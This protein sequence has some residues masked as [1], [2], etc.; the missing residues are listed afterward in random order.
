MS[1]QRPSDRNP[2]GSRGAAKGLTDTDAGKRLEFV[3]PYRDTGPNVQSD[4]ADSSLSNSLG[5]IYDRGACMANLVC[6]QNHSQFSDIADSLSRMKINA[7]NKPECHS[8]MSE[9]STTRDKFHSNSI[10][11]RNT[12]EDSIY[13]R[14]VNSLADTRFSEILAGRLNDR[15]H[16]EASG[17]DQ[18]LLN[19][20]IHEFTENNVTVIQPT[21]DGEFG[22]K[23]SYLSASSSHMD[24]EYERDALESE[25]YRIRNRSKYHVN[26]TNAE[27]QGLYTSDKIGKHKNRQ[28]PR[29]ISD[30]TVN[31]HVNLV[32]PLLNRHEESM[33]KDK[34]DNIE[35]NTTVDNSVKEHMFISTIS[36]SEQLITA[37]IRTP[38][39]RALQSVEGCHKS[40][41]KVGVNADTYGSELITDISNLSAI[42]NSKVNSTG[43]HEV[44]TSK[45][46]IFRRLSQQFYQSPTKF[47]EDLITLIEESVLHSKLEDVHASD[48]S[49]SRLTE[50]FRKICQYKRIED[51]SVPESAFGTS[52]QILSSQSGLKNQTVGN[53]SST[54]AVAA[55]SPK[56]NFTK[57]GG[58]K[59]VYRKTPRRVIKPCSMPN[60]ANVSPGTPKTTSDTNYIPDVNNSTATFELFENLCCANSPTKQEQRVQMADLDVTEILNMEDY[61]RKSDRQM[62]ALEESIQFLEEIENGVK[63]FSHNENVQPT[64]KESEAQSGTTVVE[65][66]GPNENNMEVNGKGNCQKIDKNCE[67]R[68]IEKRSKCFEEARKVFEQQQSSVNVKCTSK[69]SASHE[70]QS[71]LESVSNAGFVSTL[72]ACVDYFD[73]IRAI[74]NFQKSLQCILECSEETESVKE[75]TEDSRQLEYV[76]AIILPIRNRDNIPGPKSSATSKPDPDLGKSNLITQTHLY[77]SGS[78]RSPNPGDR[79]KSPMK[80]RRLSPG[81]RRSPGTQASSVLAKKI[82]SPVS[83]SRRQNSHRVKTNG[84]TPQ[85]EITT[86]ENRRINCENK[87]RALSGRS[88]NKSTAHLSLKLKPA[89]SSPGLTDVT[90]INKPQIIPKIVITNSTPCDFEKKSVCSRNTYENVEIDCRKELGFSES[91]TPKVRKTRY[92]VTPT[93]S[94]QPARA[95]I[96]YNKK[97][98]DFRTPAKYKVPSKSPSSPGIMRVNYDSVE[99]PVAM[100]IKGTEPNLIKNVKSKTNERMLTPRSITPKSRSKVSSPILA[101]SPRLSPTRETARL[102]FELSPAKRKKG[103]QEFSDIFN[104]ALCESDPSSIIGTECISK[105]PFPNIFYK[106]ASCVKMV[107]ET[108][109][110]KRRPKVLASGVVA[111]LIYRHEGR[112][113][114]TKQAPKQAQIADSRRA[115]HFDTTK[116]SSQD[117]GDI[118]VLHQRHATKTN[119]LIKKK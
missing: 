30:E 62:A 84:R 55:L 52:F 68:L 50:E 14:T 41:T 117:S 107:E 119:Y 27:E 49:L 44:N 19:I 4:S 36:K 15:E 51:E 100:Y 90:N 31:F 6:S 112:L 24:S 37:D 32:K 109:P 3:A 59:K 53:V 69:V 58:G 70:N 97:F 46:K 114:S 10:I 87:Q 92:F 16:V 57:F 110:K 29:I 60:C 8:N 63:Q 17:D 88:R 102:K 66:N 61:I 12:P 111:K 48:V 64:L 94:N 78:P 115:A 105:S 98:F 72:S 25:G 33:S 11:S 40:S 28:Q 83:P 34:N 9:N 71:L 18:S 96:T 79:L 80:S 26:F 82:K 108:L 73:E 99:S 23:D 74:R 65:N 81:G 118:S 1:F 95:K 101:R 2:S 67:V 42:C 75:S 5:I 43:Y 104:T 89:A 56:H 103:K 86:P 85:S 20:A 39:L 93:N 77:L 106:P 54:N 45:A 116:S 91:V 13:H 22:E 7:E 47:T 76:E 35:K 21:S 38:N 113:E